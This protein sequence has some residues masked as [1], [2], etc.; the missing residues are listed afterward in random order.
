MGVINSLGK[1]P[2]LRFMTSDYFV[3]HTPRNDLR[4]VYQRGVIAKKSQ[5]FCGNPYC[6][7]PAF[8][9][10]AKLKNDCD[11]PN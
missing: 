5:D 6:Y 11:L 1:K 8:V 9:T 10:L 7:P 3:V 2:N 4:K